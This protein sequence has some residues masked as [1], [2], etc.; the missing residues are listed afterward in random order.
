[1]EKLDHSE[2]IVKM[3]KYQQAITATANERDWVFA[4]QLTCEFIG[5]LSE[6]AKCFIARLEEEHDKQSR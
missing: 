4:T 5:N 3:Y 6:M 2:Y 1:M